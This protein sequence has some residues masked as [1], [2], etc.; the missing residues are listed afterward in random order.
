MLAAPTDALVNFR[1][2]D[3]L[4]TL[5]RGADYTSCSPSRQAGTKGERERGGGREGEGERGRER[6]SRATSVTASSISPRAWA[7]VRNRARLSRFRSQGERES[8]E[9]RERSHF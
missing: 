4:E 3:E 8:G 9:T 6:Q 5:L 7:D 2:R 1:S